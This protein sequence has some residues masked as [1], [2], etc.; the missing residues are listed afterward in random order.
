MHL[1]L[2]TIA[3]AHS[4]NLWSRIV[5]ENSGSIW[6]RIC[7]GSS[8]ARASIVVVRLSSFMSFRR[9]SVEV[10]DFSPVML[11]TTSHPSSGRFLGGN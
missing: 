2:A 4:G 3:R 11:L 1:Y 7:F 9:S 10:L 5:V 8:Y 6:Y